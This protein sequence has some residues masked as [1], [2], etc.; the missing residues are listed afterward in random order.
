MNLRDFALLVSVCLI[1]GL[2]NVL[3]KVVVG[4]WQIPPLFFAAARFGLVLLVTLPWL[5]PVP[6]QLGR[7]IAIGMLMG[8]GNFALLFIGLQTATP[9]AAA[10]VIQAGVPITTLLSVL[11]LGERIHWRR[12]LGIILTLIGVLIVVWQPGFALSDGLL[13]VLGAAFAGSLGAILMKQA[14]DL[15]PLRYQAWVA[16]TS[17]VPLTLATL[18]LEDGQWATSLAAGWPFLAA[19]L[20]SALVVSVGAHT[21]YYGL[22][23]RHE[24]NLLAPLTLI[25]PIATIAL[26]VLITGDLLD[27]R[28][29][30]GSAIALLGV[31]I[32]ALRRTGAPIAQSQEHA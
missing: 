19:L 8:G 5:R 9:S 16:L 2:S 21:A 30:A 17:V 25:T 11:M 32:V 1:W 29:I 10:V 12:A 20:F 26:G 4:S 7:I 27:A 23:A 14:D 6:R 18:W 22:I 28:M 31:L 15:A 3:S 24:A 13:F